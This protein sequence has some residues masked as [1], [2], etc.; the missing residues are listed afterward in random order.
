MGMNGILVD[1]MHD[2]DMEGNAVDVAEEGSA[3]M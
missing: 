3:H 1:C 2:S